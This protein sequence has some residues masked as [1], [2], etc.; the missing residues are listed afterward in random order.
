[1]AFVSVYQDILNAVDARINSLA[2]SH[3]G[4]LIPVKQRKLPSKE[5]EIDTVPLIVNCP[6]DR[7]EEIEQ[8]SFEADSGVF[9]TYHIET[10]LMFAGARD[11]L[12]NLDLVFSFREQMRRL[13]QGPPLL[14]TG[15]NLPK[16]WN[17][18]PD[19]EYVLDRGMINQNYDYSGLAWWFKTIEQRFN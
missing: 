4:S 18:L 14:G 5:E 16:V 2:L 6:Q 12:T 9:V 1:M 3:Q 10:V 7:P 13:F 8:A 15:I 11:L 17:V 19:L